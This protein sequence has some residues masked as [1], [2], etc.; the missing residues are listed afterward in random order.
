MTAVK[1]VER[2]KYGALAVYGKEIPD[3]IQ[4]EIR[5]GAISLIWAEDGAGKKQIAVGSDFIPIEKKIAPLQGK[6]YNTYNPTDRKLPVFLALL[7][8]TEALPL[9]QENVI[10]Y[11]SK[12]NPKAK[13]ILK[14]SKILQDRHLIYAYPH[15]NI[16]FLQTI[17][18]SEIDFSSQEAF[19]GIFYTNYPVARFIMG[20]KKFHNFIMTPERIYSEASAQRA[21]QNYF[22]RERSVSYD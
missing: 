16:F 10:A 6:L 1:K 13:E 2:A 18:H 12:A 19:G 20:Y 17:P 22:E 11:L 5:V 7:W 3:D 21:L 9:I 4:K 14:K 15:E 8:G